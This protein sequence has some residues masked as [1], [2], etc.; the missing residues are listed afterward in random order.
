VVEF[1]L[2]LPLL[3]LVL[4]GITE[5]GRAIATVEVLNAA[6]R[7]GARIA[8]VTAPDQTL[9]TNRVNQVL[10]AAAITPSSIIVVGPV[11]SPESTVQ[12]TVQSDFQVLSASVLPFQGTITLQGVSVMRHEG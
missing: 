2:V 6:A 8:A 3:L 11:G 4:F 7:E 9:V 12:V 5:F 10:A 1:A